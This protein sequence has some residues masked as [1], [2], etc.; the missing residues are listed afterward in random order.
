MI[1]P[2]HHT[3]GDQP[4]LGMCFCKIVDKDNLEDRQFVS[5]RLTYTPQRRLIDEPITARLLR[6]PVVGGAGDGASRLR[7]LKE[8]YQ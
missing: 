7:H 3:C 4:T 1:F 2:R 5:I 8:Q 6:A